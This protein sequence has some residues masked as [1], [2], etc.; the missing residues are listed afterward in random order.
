[1]CTKIISIPNINTAKNF[2]NM[3]SKYMNLKIMLTCEDYEID[4]HSI[5]GI[6]SL[7][8]D[9]PIELVTDENC[10]QEFLND[11]SNYEIKQ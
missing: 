11:I 7:N 6:L 5:M 3:A 1:M 9:K 8:M 2:V 4:G 10:P